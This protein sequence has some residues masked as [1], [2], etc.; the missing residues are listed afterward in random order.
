[1]SL[2]LMIIDR[3]H[4]NRLT[5]FVILTI[6]TFPTTRFEIGFNLVIVV[7]IYIMKWY[8]FPENLYR[9]QF[10]QFKFP[11]AQTT[12]WYPFIYKIR[13]IQYHRSIA[14]LIS[15]KKGNQSKLE[16]QCKL[17]DGHISILSG[18]RFVDEQLIIIIYNPDHKCNLSLY[19]PYL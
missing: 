10:D 4:L 19:L 8:T 5:I 16:S 3:Q 17:R 12:C 6:N 1:M 15:T 18:K 11:D 2:L 7:R 14:I 9:L 13:T